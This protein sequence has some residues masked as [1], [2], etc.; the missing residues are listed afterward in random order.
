MISKEYEIYLLTLRAL[1]LLEEI[2][3][4]ENSL[5]KSIRGLNRFVE[6]ANETME[7][8]S[9]DAHQNSVHNFN[10]ILNSIDH[11]TLELPIGTL[12]IEK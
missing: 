9:T 3:T 11:E 6:G 7:K 12:T 1:S 8:V 2:G 5:K 10:V 4:P